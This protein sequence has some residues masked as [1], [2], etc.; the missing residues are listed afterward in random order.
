MVVVLMC[1]N[2]YSFICFI[3]CVVA[4][5]E[6]SGSHGGDV[7]ERCA[8]K[9]GFLGEMRDVYLRKG[10]RQRSSASSSTLLLSANPL[11]DRSQAVADK[12]KN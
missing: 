7:R 9:S 2:F 4:V 10:L 11:A 5:G 1:I 12:S 3:L 6:G 8:S